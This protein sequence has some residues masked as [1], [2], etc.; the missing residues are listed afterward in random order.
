MLLDQSIDTLK[1]LPQINSTVDL[2]QLNNELDQLYVSAAN[3][4]KMIN[5]TGYTLDPEL[6]WPNAA[7]HALWAQYILDNVT[8]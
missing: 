5:D 4:R 1:D 7:A 6:C 2:T 3:L 8:F